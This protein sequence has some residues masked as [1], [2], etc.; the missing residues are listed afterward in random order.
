VKEKILITGASGLLGRA[1]VKN[2]LARNF[3]VFAQYNS[4]RPVL[5]DNCQWLWADFSQLEGIKDFLHQNQTLLKGCSYLINNY[6]PITS[7]PFSELK[8]EDFIFDYHHNVIT[9]FEITNFLIKNALL[10]SVVNIGF[11]FLGRNR[12]YKKILTYASAKNS[13]LLL[14]RSFIREYPDI[15]FSIISLP[16]LEGAEVKAKS[17]VRLSPDTAAREIYK[18]L[19]TQKSQSPLKEPSFNDIHKDE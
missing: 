12:S 19:K 3:L 15:N 9:T 7:K 8:S 6:G 4:H 5:H 16:T 13:L 17:K 10:Q 18:L 2:F 1:L 11:E 14:T